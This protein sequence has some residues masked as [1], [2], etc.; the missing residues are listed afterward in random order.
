MNRIVEPHK[1]IAKHHLGVAACLFADSPP[2]QGFAALQFRRS[3]DGHGAGEVTRL[4]HELRVLPGDARRRVDVEER[5]RNG[6]I[7]RRIEP[8]VGFFLV[9]S[10]EAQLE[11]RRSRREQLPAERDPC[12]RSAVVV[13][14]II[15]K[16]DVRAGSA[17]GAGLSRSGGRDQ[18]WHVHPLRPPIQVL[19]ASPEHP[20][21]RRRAVAFDAGIAAGVLV[22]LAALFV[23]FAALVYD[24]RPITA[25]PDRCLFDHLRLF[26]IAGMPVGRAADAAFV[27]RLKPDG[28]AE[29]GLLERALCIN[30]GRAD[31]G[32]RRGQCGGGDFGRP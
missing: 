25:R 4:R 27:R 5:P 8:E 16:H 32:E 29:Y 15:A 9:E 23:D 31:R 11:A 2:E 6:R 17:E 18:G 30:F 7:R 22:D 14:Q 20:L 12:A 26:G 24:C 10:E 3:V 21:H 19:A 1:A 28:A 13:D